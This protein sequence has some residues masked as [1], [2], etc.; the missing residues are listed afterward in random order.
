MR[1]A[2]TTD[3][4]PGDHVEILRGKNK[5]KRGFVDRCED[6]Q[7]IVRSP[8]TGNSKSF[9]RSWLWL[10]PSVEPQ[11]LQP[12]EGEPLHVEVQPLQG[13]RGPTPTTD[14]GVQPTQPEPAPPLDQGV[15]E[16]QPLQA[17]EG[18]PLQALEALR[19]RLR[20]AGVLEDCWI[21]NYS[22]GS[23]S[24]CRLVWHQKINRSPTYFPARDL[25]QTRECIDRGRVLRHLDAVIRYLE[26]Q[27]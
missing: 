17:V 15:V 8:V 18:E 20:A 27:D 19:D 5:G 14:V 25:V 3:F 21:E 11:P 23:A 6:D 1:E 26:A 2:S 12:V 13:G 16:V 7:V 4:K 9:P 24:V 10:L 22:R